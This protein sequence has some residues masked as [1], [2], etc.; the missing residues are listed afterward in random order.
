MPG[1]IVCQ[2]FNLCAN[3]IFIVLC[4]VNTVRNLVGFCCLPRQHPDSLV[5][6]AL[7][8]K[9]LKDFQ[10][11]KHICKITILNYCIHYS[12]ENTRK[13]WIIDFIIVLSKFDR[14]IFVNLK[15]ISYL[16]CLY[17]TWFLIWKLLELAIT[18]FIIC[19]EISGYFLPLEFIKRV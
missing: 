11:S 12:Y 7:S 15:T 3:V 13:I 1:L 14:S 2:E 9:M 19:S 8:Q 17:T 16:F 10:I 18:M 4:K 5:K 6:V